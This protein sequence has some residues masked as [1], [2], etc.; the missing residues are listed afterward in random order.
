VLLP[1][2]YRTIGFVLMREDL[3]LPL[4]ALHLF[5]LARAARLRSATAF[6][7]AGLALGAALATW[8]AMTFVVALEA[9]CFLA[10]LLW[11]GESPFAERR[12]L[13]V[14][15]LVA[16]FA[17]AVPALRAR[18]ALLSLPLQLAA[19][20][21]VPALTGWTR[22]FARRA[23]VVLGTWALL[24]GA[25]RLVSGADLSHVW[26]VM[27]AKLAH[28]GRLPADPA[29][30]S[31]EA[32]ML[33]QGP[34]ES[35]TLA[36]LLSRLNVGLLLAAAFL[37][38][39]ARDL[40]R[41]TLER[42][43]G[44]LAL[45]LVATLAAGVLVGRMLI[46]AGLLVP[47]AGALVIGRATMALGP[48]RRGARRALVGAAVA[49]QLLG[50]ASWRSGFELPWHRPR[51]RQLEIRALADAVRRHVPEGEAVA[52]DFLTS[53][54]LLASTQRPIVLEP[55]WETAASRARVRELWEAFFQ[56]STED[57]RRLLVERYR[58][59]WLVVERSALFGPTARYLAGMRPGQFVPR[60]GSPAW[61]LLS[62][63]DSVL[64]SVPGYRLVWRSPPDLRLPDGS[65]SDFVRLYRLEG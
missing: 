59:R 10:W 47:V 26:E 40:A 38:L 28:L 34:F 27:G 3:S 33:W 51:V 42:A 32:R 6:A 62:S 37:A 31:F 46:V 25:S 1:V 9:A 36:Y 50:F 61:F 56:G 65:P 60:V 55:K 48:R 43:T 22:P 12:A 58:C 13:W 14:P 29:A 19:A 57:L 64:R 23:L 41:G 8:H 17:L 63:D 35:P 49:A 52:A 15:A 39:T 21:I 20:L 24:L 45:M 4:F 16:L 18:D 54:A 44:L 30:L 5:L 7:L 11:T 53:A 2:G